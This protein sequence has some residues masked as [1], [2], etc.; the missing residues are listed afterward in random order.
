M[1]EG[2]LPPLWVIGAGGHAK[3]VVATARAAGFAV[4]GVIA[5]R[6]ESG[7][8]AVL[9]VPITVGDDALPPGAAAVVAIG[10]NRT[11]E[12]LVAE[13]EDAQWTSVVHPRAFLAEGTS[14]GAGSVVFALAVVQPGAEV[15]A[16]VIVNTGA[17][18]EHDVVLGDLSQ[19]ASGAVLTGGVRIGRG[20]F[21]GAG[22]TVLP[23]VNVGEW[24]T[25]GAGAVVNRDVPSGVTVVGVPARPL[26]HDD[27]I[28]SRE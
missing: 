7:Q 15:G 4:A 22:A 17:L 11:R 24:A 1:S 9:G 16:H 10:D 14:L 5:G 6:P 28:G 8:T 26:P 13:L 12:R 23:G 27:A 3:V 19:V 18:I 2:S 20:A 25:V 21:V